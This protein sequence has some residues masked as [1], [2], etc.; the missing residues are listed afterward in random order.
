MADWSATTLSTLQSISNYE[1]EINNLLGTYTAPCL[2]VANIGDYI[3]VTPD[4]LTS[5][6]SY[7]SNG[8]TDT[9]LYNSGTKR[10][11]FG[12]TGNVILIVD[13]VANKT[14]PIVSS[15]GTTFQ[16]TGGTF[17][18]AQGTCDLSTYEAQAN[19]TAKITLAKTLLGNR[20]E[21]GL[22]DRGI[23]VDEAG[24]QVLLDVVANPTIFMQ[25]SDF[26]AL[27]LIYHDLYNQRFTDTY[28]KT[29]QYYE[30]EYDKEFASCMKRIN[31]DQSLSGV[32]DTYRANFIGRLER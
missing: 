8:T 13:T 31:L 27:A 6:V 32:T 4:T 24:G 21:E 11:A 5:L 20:I 14:F 1:A 29:W 22:T 25:C 7:F 23:I 30:N 9:M 10:W 19:W 26:K 2:V 17:T 28:E 3:T 12:L 16:D 15:D 18:I